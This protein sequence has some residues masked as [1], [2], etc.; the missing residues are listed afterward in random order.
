MKLSPSFL[1]SITELNMLWG[2]IIDNPATFLITS[3]KIIQSGL[4]RFT[5]LS[6]SEAM[7]CIR[8][9]EFIELCR[10]STVTLKVCS[11]FILA[12]ISLMYLQ[13]I[14][15]SAWATFSIGKTLKIYLNLHGS[16]LSISTSISGTEIGFNSVRHTSKPLMDVDSISA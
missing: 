16:S 11:G 8:Q 6:I 10:F 7:P 15:S 5:F 9:F 4:D 13:I 1:I 3:T 14:S 12:D 2:L